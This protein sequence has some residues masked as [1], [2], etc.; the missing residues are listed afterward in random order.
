MTI[1]VVNMT[2]DVI[3]DA[4]L[5]CEIMSGEIMS[6]GYCKKDVTQ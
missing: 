1:A 6:M 2:G 5:L 4:I 3:D